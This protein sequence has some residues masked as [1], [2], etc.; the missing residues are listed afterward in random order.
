MITKEEIE[1]LRNSNKDNLKKEEYEA[2]MAKFKSESAAAVERFENVID[3]SFRN[4]IKWNR[5]NDEC[6]KSVIVAFKTKNIFQIAAL[7]HIIKKYCNAGFKV[8]P[9]VSKIE[10]KRIYSTPKG[11]NEMFE[12]L[13][14]NQ[15]S[16]YEPSFVRSGEKLDNILEKY[17]TIIKTFTS[18]DNFYTKVV[19]ENQESFDFFELYWNDKS[20]D[21]LEKIKNK[22]ILNGYPL[23]Y[24]EGFVPHIGKEQVLEFSLE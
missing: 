7:S 17:D 24:L 19:K 20:E 16:N 11:K 12:K 3:N 22:D 2:A 18:F 23:H 10:E 1:I 21:V 15:Y 8:F 14:A 4:R 9:L 5:E 13:I 6:K